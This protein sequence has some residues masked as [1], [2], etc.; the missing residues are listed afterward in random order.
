MDVGGRV[1]YAQGAGRLAAGEEYSFLNF[2]GMHGNGM[3]SQVDLPRRGT[4]FAIP[5]FFVEGAH[6]LRA[7]P[8]MARRDYRPRGA[9]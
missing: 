6:D 9:T 7:T 4:D 3:L 8:D 2:V 1:Q 5:M